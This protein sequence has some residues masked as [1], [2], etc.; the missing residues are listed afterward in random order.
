MYG[1][2]HG[3]KM[4]IGGI[5]TDEL[6]QRQRA[7][8]IKKLQH[9]VY[10]LKKDP[11]YTT[12]DMGI[13]E[14]SLC[15]TTHRTPEGYIQHTE[16][17]KHRDSLHLRQFHQ[18]KMLASKNQVAQGVAQGLGGGKGNS[19]LSNPK[20]HQQQ[21]ISRP[22]IGL[23]QYDVVKQY[24]PDTGHHAIAF[25]I[26][27]PFIEQGLRPRYELLSVFQQKVEQ[28]DP[29]FQYLVFA[30]EPYN[31]MA[32]KIPNVP[33]AAKRILTDWDT[34]TKTFILQMGFSDDFESKF[35]TTQEALGA[36]SLLQ[37]DFGTAFD[38]NDDGD[39]DIGDDDDDDMLGIDDVT[40]GDYAGTSA[41]RSN[42]VPDDID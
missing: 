8:Q 38:G 23:P 6:L 34:T 20:Q 30:A 10:D 18:K 19:L 16:G 35:R 11:Y 1:R 13:I 7:Q 33:R 25:K 15:K 2:E 5:A 21:F 26:H 4:G 41:S 32:V 36:K 27:Y 42:A 17:K 37:E 39:D 3:V 29:R 31:N 28:P 12:T 9:D 22:T 24:C 14:C 40:M